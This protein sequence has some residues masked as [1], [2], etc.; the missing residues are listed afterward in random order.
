MMMHIARSTLS[1]LLFALT[2]VAPGL[3]SASQEQ[4]V[5]VQ[6]QAERRTAIQRPG[7]QRPV[8][9]SEVTGALPFVRTELYFGTA[10]PEGVVTDA[11]F[12][13][14]VDRYVTPEFPD[15]LTLL[16]GDG[17]FRGEGDIIVKEQSFVLVLLYPYDT[18]N[19]SSAKIER[20]R[21]LYKE[22]F[23]QESV[24]RSDDAFIV[25]VSF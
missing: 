20:I 3:T 14:F 21:N 5:Q 25:W 17:Q 6:A 11:E 18:F 10:K 2:T 23:Q 7:I 19:E 24:L 22:A 4:S 13:D 12:R 8:P 16:T 15:G 1:A 9:T